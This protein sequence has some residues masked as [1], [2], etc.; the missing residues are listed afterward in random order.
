MKIWYFIRNELHCFPPCVS[1][2]YYLNDMGIDLTVCFGQCD[3]KLMKQ[4]NDRKINLIDLKIVRSKNKYVGKIQSI[5]EYKRSFKKI[6]HDKI[7]QDDVI[8]FAT[9]DSA[10]MVKND[11]ISGKYKFILNCL[12][13]Y[14][15][16]EYYK[17]NI[18][19]IINYANAV[20]ACEPNRAA[21]MQSWYR[22]VNRPYVMPNKPYSHPQKRLI[23]GSTA[24][25]RDAVTSI[26]GKKIIIYQGMISPDRDLSMVAKALS[27]LNSDLY[28]VL[29][30]SEYYNGVKTIKSIYSKTIYLGYIVAPLHLEITSYATIGIA[31]YD[32]SCL[33]NVFCAPNKIYEYA[34]FGIPMLCNDVV[35]LTN[36]VGKYNAGV[37]TN[38]NDVKN[39]VDSINKILEFYDVMSNNAKKLY[40]DCDN[41]KTIET[42][43]KNL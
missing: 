6:A 30:G 18:N 2:I 5:L 32:Y 35:G 4:L 19:K 1:Q 22:L 3:D 43:V 7:S 25:L 15:D 12:E 42:I 36:T 23:S 16:N 37:C 8:W 34:G 14:D 41:K 29:M 26:R 27:I 31:N 38:F 39:I 20:V 10:F 40:L 17:R 28:L 24:E 9:A 33:N 11:L 21:I 13:L